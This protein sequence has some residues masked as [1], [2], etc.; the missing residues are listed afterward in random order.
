[1]KY[2]LISTP[3]TQDIFKKSKISVAVPLLPYASLANL[4]AVLLEEKQEVKILDLRLS[5]YPL[6]DLKKCIGSF[7]PDYIGITFTTPLFKEASNLVSYI[8]KLNKEIKIIAGGPHIS[9]LFYESIKEVDFDIVVV[10]EGEETIR[11]IAQNKKLNEI[12]GILYRD[13]GKIETNKPRELIQDIDNLPFPAWHLFDLSKYKTPRISCKRNPVGPLETS[14][15]CT[16]G[17]VYCSKCTF[18]RQFRKK[19]VERVVKDIEQMLRAGFK[20]IHIL[21]DMF[22]TDLERAKKICDEI[23]NRK[24]CFTWSLINGIRVDR[25]DEEL[26][27]KLKQ[28]G[29]Y[30]IAF[31]VESGDESV[32]KI[33]NKGITLP[34]IRMAFKLANKVGIESVAFCMMGLPGD[35]KE[36]MQ[37]TI[38]L[39]K[40]VKPTMP[41]TSILLPL[42]G[43][44]LFEEWDK[45]GLILT[46]KWEDYSFHSSKRV[47]RHPNLTDEEI[48]TYYKKFWR[49]LMLSPNFLLK[50]I[51]RDIKTGELFYDFY[52][53]MKTLKFGW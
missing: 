38:D 2:L 4:A 40:E 26:L 13:C 42:P 22:S 1:M 27:K 39:M 16:Y 5:E 23:I 44:P 3:E 14:R 52:Y 10:G 29:C 34:K 51:V 31:G 7:S 25:V 24:L 46:K 11:E 8:K 30:R 9:A 43:T 53:F 28:A 49:E 37:K 19:S 18:K 36:S 48:F 47:Y 50:R 45:K 35:T 15:G 32:L 33:I 21:D 12:K 20:E 41:K 17:C 6:L